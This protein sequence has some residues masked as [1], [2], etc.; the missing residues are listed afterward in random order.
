MSIYFDNRGIDFVENDLVSRPESDFHLNN[1]NVIVFPE[2]L[3]EGINMFHCYGREHT[4]SP[5]IHDFFIADGFHQD[6]YFVLRK[7][8]ER[9]IVPFALAILEPKMADY[10]QNDLEK[11]Y[12]KDRNDY[13]K[14][15]RTEGYG[16]R[17]GLSE[18]IS[19]PLVGKFEAF[20]KR[21]YLILRLKSVKKNSTIFW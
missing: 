14:Q 18:K 16:R 8:L 7:N 20:L 9:N 3:A 4:Q 21:F 11:R 10:S 2:R 17:I 12:Q 1:D 13:G 6:V 5:I 15:G 19:D